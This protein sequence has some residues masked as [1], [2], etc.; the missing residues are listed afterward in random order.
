MQIAVAGFRAREQ[1]E[2]RIAEEGRHAEDRGRE[3]RGE[4]I[5]GEDHHRQSD[6][7]E[8]ESRGPGPPSDSEPREE[9]HGQPGQRGEGEH[10]RRMLGGELVG[11]GAHEGQRP[12]EQDTAG[13]GDEHA[14]GLRS[15]SL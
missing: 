9:N 2:N 3:E 11:V 15:F 5:S 1:P 7:G 8:G 12:K 13:D 6:G 10:R 14:T 4:E